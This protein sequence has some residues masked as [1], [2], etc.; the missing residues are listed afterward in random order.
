MFRSII[1]LNIFRVLYEALLGLGMIIDVDILK[2]DSQCSKLIH[3]LAILIK[4][5]RY[6][7][8]LTMALRYLQ[9]SLLGPEVKVLLHLL[10]DILNSF[11]FF[12]FKKLN[13]L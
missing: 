8:L 4:L 12:F 6:E 11:F 5:L 13:D 1:G 10:I 3:I 7:L 9:D 2:C